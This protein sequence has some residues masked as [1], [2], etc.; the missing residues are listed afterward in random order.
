M[1]RSV[2]DIYNRAKQ[3][4]Y[5]ASKENSA[6]PILRK[7]ASMPLIINRDEHMTEPKEYE[8]LKIEKKD[9]S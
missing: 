5:A 7:N 2:R 4:L 3:V 8:V 9:E 6:R 1:A